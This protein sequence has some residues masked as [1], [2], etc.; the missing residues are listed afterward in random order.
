MDTQRGGRERTRAARGH[1]VAKAPEGERE[2]PAV[3]PCMSLEALPSA[4]A[5]HAVEM[6]ATSLQTYLHTVLEQV[7]RGERAEALT[8]SEGLA[9]VAAFIHQ[10][11]EAYHAALERQYEVVAWAEKRQVGPA[12]RCDGGAHLPTHVARRLA[13]GRIADGGGR[14]RPPPA[15]VGL[16]H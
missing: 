15:S 3:E 9:D 16:P 11:P 14:M 5:A 1:A 10:T 12:Q 6:A 4:L 8:L 7:Q 2:Q 13:A